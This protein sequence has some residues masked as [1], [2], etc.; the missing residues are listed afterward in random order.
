MEDTATPPPA[1]LRCLGPPRLDSPGGSLALEERRNAEPIE[2][3]LRVVAMGPAGMPMRTLSAACWPELTPRQC[4]ARLQSATQALALLAGSE[5]VPLRL[6]GEL[7][8]VDRQALEV[9]SLQ[10]EEA[11]APL[12]TPYQREGDMAPGARAAVSRAIADEAVFLPDL[13]APWA[14]AARMRIADKLVRAV[15]RL[16]STERATT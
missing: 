11:I 1:R 13:D 3:L 10:L 8:N 12:I 14:T 9:D 7:V 15:R 5:A 6:D 16:A 2:V 4:H